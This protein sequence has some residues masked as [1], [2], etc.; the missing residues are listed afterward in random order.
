MIQRHIK[1]LLYA[2]DCVIIPDFG[3]LITHYAPAK[4]HPVKH[5]F[6]PP[7]KHI[8]FNEQLKV[9]D[10][11]LISTLAK[12]QQLP[13]NLAQQAV[14]E[15][16]QDL[17]AQLLQQHR[18]ELQDIG[19]FRYNAD[20]QLVFESI[21][22][23]NF[24]EQSFGLPDLVSKPIAGKE[25]LILRGKYKD[26]TPGTDNNRKQPVGRFRKLYRIGASLVIGT[27]T[28]SAVYLFSLQQDVALS[29]LN[30]F[31]LL[32]PTETAV[33]AI[34]AEA[35]LRE[36][37]EINSYVN[38]TAEDSFNQEAEFVD[39]PAEEDNWG[40]TDVTN[41]EVSTVAETALEKKPSEETTVAAEA[42]VT[43]PEPAKPVKAEAAVKKETVATATKAAAKSVEG[44]TIKQKT[45]RFYVIMGV[46]SQEGYAE[47]NQKQLQRKGY[48]AKILQPSHDTK[49]DRVSVADF[50]TAQEAQNALPELRNKINNE[51]WVFNY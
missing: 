13:L 11:L 25:S 43:A 17:K 37:E 34:D 42:K 35:T 2:Y 45:G 10:G 9:N 7:S 32:T 24:L 12:Q 16:V 33:P 36:S 5:T 46:F 49:R 41:S 40:D 3:G 6:S 18:F 31:A 23:D 29:S 44:A 48:D 38:G 19:V 14:A 20:R 4:I 22:S 39:A 15:F 26:Q 28:V 1:N 8:A 51:L 27:L 30:P 50:A 47:R 21:E